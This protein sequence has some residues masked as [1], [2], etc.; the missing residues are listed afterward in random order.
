MLLKERYVRIGGMTC[1]NCQNRIEKALK[2]AEGISEV[3][4][5]YADGTA[6][7]QYDAGV[8]S[9]DDIEA[10]VE[11]AGYEVLAINEAPVKAE[12]NWSRAAG[13]IAVILALAMIVRH[14]NIPLFNAFP[15]AQAG[16]GF[17]MLFVIGLITSVHCLAMCGGINLSQTL[18]A[19]ETSAAAGLSAASSLLPSFLYNGGRVLSYTAVGGIVG[20]A[21]SVLSL[22]GRARGVIQIIAGIFMVI[23]GLNMLGIFPALRRLMPH[24]PSFITGKIGG[25]RAKSKSPL[26]IGLLNGLMPCGP[27]QAM[28]L[29]ALSTGSAARGALSMLLFS[30]GTVP[31]MFGLGALG[32]FLSSRPSIT[33]RVMTAGACVVA[34][35]GITMFF[36]GTALSGFSLSSLLPASMRASVSGPGTVAKVS[37]GVQIVNTTLTPGSYPAITVQAGIPVRWTMDAPA[38]SINGC[39]IALNIPEYDIQYRFKQGENLIE[40]TPDKSGV[41][42]YS[43][44]MGMIRGTITV[45]ADAA[46][47]AQSALDAANAPSGAYG[48]EPAEAPPVPASYTIPV[49]DI[50]VAEPGDYQGN[51]IQRVR[52]KLTDDGYE[53]AVVVVE[54][55]VPAEWVIDNESIE[56]GSA[57]LR[58]PLYRTAIPLQKQALNAL[59]LM[60]ADD[61]AFSTADG[62]FFGYVKAVDDLASFDRE[63]LKKEVAAFETLIYPDEYYQQEG[64]A[65]CCRQ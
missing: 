44:W 23:M 27:L 48:V 24:L 11:K 50:A 16:M 60:P 25:A 47:L 45:V 46:A 51:K 35:M 52:I 63:A 13:L 6:K 36:Q 26:V 9:L 17:G 31:L 32:S 3:T 34:V 1:V 5:S 65:G 10:V 49:D 12:G 40:F 54:K 8:I 22:S 56:D 39:N 33:R 42:R 18:G 41:F 2:A 43:C 62:I 4:V 15:T 53:P 57:E 59:Y 7:V 38:G 61:F 19:A 37:G 55:G 20:A 21:G 64:S 28:Q 29:Y 58:A 30:L 14:L